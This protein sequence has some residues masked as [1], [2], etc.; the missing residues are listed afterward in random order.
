MR[1]PGKKGE[2]KQ[3]GG[4]KEGKREWERWGGW[5]GLFAVCERERGHAERGEWRS[6]VK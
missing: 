1:G 3:Q 2:E 4:D 5:G 6:R